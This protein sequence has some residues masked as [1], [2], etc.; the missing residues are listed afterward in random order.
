VILDGQAV[1]SCTVLPRK[2]TARPSRRS[3]S[4]RTPLNRKRLR[5]E[6]GPVVASARP[7]IM[8]ATAAGQQPEPERGGDRRGISGNL[9]RCTATQYRQSYQYGAAKMREL[10]AESTQKA[11]HA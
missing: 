1:K 3:A 4:S 9:C 8:T 2:S 5:Q 6:H 7:A 10:Q 11:T